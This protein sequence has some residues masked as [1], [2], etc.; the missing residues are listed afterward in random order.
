MM[1]GSVYAFV[2][3][4]LMAVLP[5][6]SEAQDNDI[7]KQLANPIASLTVVPIQTNFDFKIGPAQNGS[8]VTTNIQPVVPLS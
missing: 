3:G 6:G 1:R 5:S 8:R 2:V 7:Q 4:A